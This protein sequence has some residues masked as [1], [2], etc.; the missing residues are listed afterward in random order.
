MITL[1]RLF[2]ASLPNISLVMHLIETYFRF[3]HPLR[4]FGFIHKPSFVQ[5]VEQQ[6]EDDRNN[7]PLLLV[8]CALSAR[9]A[10]VPTQVIYFS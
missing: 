9:W 8:V 5:K 10:L 3:I 7:D 4:S 6:S 1:S 2:Q